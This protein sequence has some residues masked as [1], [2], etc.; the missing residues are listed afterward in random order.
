MKVGTPVVEIIHRALLRRNITHVFAYSG[1]SIL[2]LLD[3]FYDSP[4]KVI[5][6]R[7]EQCCGHAAEGYAKAANKVG[8]TIT[9]SGPGVTNLI[10]PLQDALNDFVPMLA[11]TGQV[12]TSDIG[13]GAFQECDAVALTSPCT[14]WN[15]QLQSENEI[16]SCM[17]EAL[18]IAMSAPCGPVHLDL[19]ADI[20]RNKVLDDQKI[21]I[22]PPSKICDLDPNVEGNIRKVLHMIKL[23]KKPVIYAGQGTINCVALL[24]Q[25]A[26]TFDIPVT[27]TLHAMGVFDE[28]HKLSLK[29]VGIYGSPAANYAIQSADL[30]MAIGSRFHDRATGPIS[31]YAPEA[32]LAQKEKRGGF[33]HFDINP[34]E[35]GKV[36]D[37]AI[38]L[39][40]DCAMYMKAILDMNDTDNKE[41][42]SYSQRDLAENIKCNK[43]TWLNQ[44]NEWKE[45]FQLS[46]QYPSDGKLY[47][48]RVITEINKQTVNKQDF[49][50]TTGVGCHQ[51]IACQY[52]D[53]QY[54]GSIITSG[55]LGVMGVS[56][57]FAI[58][59][60][61]A[62]PK[63]TVISIDGD[64]SF[65]MTVQD[66]GTVVEHNIPVKIALID[67]GVQTMVKYHQ[68]VFWKR[69]IIV[70]N[71]NPDY[72]K[73]GE[74][75]RI[76][77]IICED[78]D[79]LEKCVH[80]MISYSDGP[81]LA[82]FKTKSQF[83]FPFVYPGQSLDEVSFFHDKQPSFE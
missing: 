54:P 81:V 55:S 45:T 44:I 29:M 11:L 34:K 77:T 68:D 62:C 8:I 17:E 41:G 6:N 52:I 73:L 47:A 64:G 58:G 33:V 46:K 21:Q 69:N 43:Q 30:V 15:Y 83:S 65:N 82:V 63:K 67:D 4:I 32:K 38:A 40:G 53:W 16:E 76:H 13:R 20:I 42:K 5:M 57:P 51:M 78:V 56:T 25:F 31:K 2:P 59:A 23:A 26:E 71:R 35:I 74:A 60:Q 9:T 72:V 36:I 10:T 1:G 79:N 3:R 49:L 37:P 28:T 18:K 70:E 61:L 19:P 50:I 14:K 12:A 80:E 24:R 48:Q 75:Y 66:L 22:Y 7:N 39:V 27:T